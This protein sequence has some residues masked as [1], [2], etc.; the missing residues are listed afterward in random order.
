MAGRGSFIES[1]PLFG[2][3]LDDYDELFAEKLELL[4]KIRDER[5]RHLVRSPPPAA[6]R[7]RRLATSRP[8][9][10][11]GLGRGRRLAAV[12]RPRRHARPAAHDR[13]HRRAARAAS[14]R[15]SSCTARRSPAPATTPAQA[16]VAINTHAF[17]G[18]TSAQA[19]SAFAAPYL[20]GDEPHRARARL[21]AVGPARVRGA[22]LAPRGAR[23]RVAAGGRREDPLRPRA[24]RSSALH[25]P[26]ERRRRRARRR[27]ALDGALRHRGRAGGARRGGAAHGAGDRLTGASRALWMQNGRPGR[28]G[29]IHVGCDAPQGR[30]EHL[31]LE[32]E[33]HA[34][35]A[36][37]DARDHRHRLAD[38]QPRRARQ[39]FAKDAAQL[40]ARQ[41]RAEAVVHAAA[42]EADVVVRPA[43]HVEPVGILERAPVTVPRAVEHDHLLPRGDRLAADLRVAGRG[44]AERRHRARPAHELLDG[45]G[46]ARLEI[47]DQVGALARVVVER[48]RRVARRVAG[49][50][51]AGDRQQVEECGDLRSAEP[52]AVDLGVHERRHQ[53]V[54]RM[55]GALLGERG[56]HLRDRPDALPRQ[57]ERVAIP[58]DV[59][60]AEVH[61]H[62]GGLLQAL[63]VLT[64]DAD[65]LGDHPHRDLLGAELDEVALG[66]L[67]QLRDD[68]VR[69]ERDPLLE[70]RDLARREGRRDEP[71]QLRVARGV[72]RD[73]RRRRLEHLRRRVEEHDAQ[74]RA[75]GPLVARDAA[76]VVIARQ[77]PVAAAGHLG[78]QREALDRPPPGDRA[79]AAQ[80]RER[81]V[82]L[83]RRVLQ[84]ELQ[85]G[86]VEAESGGGRALDRA[87]RRRIR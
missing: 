12:G 69:V 85:R 56:R 61:Q 52:L 46:Q 74:P 27:A 60:V 9:S 10:A 5:A 68:L 39:Q 36:V 22:A 83:C 50:V 34:L 16:R 28:P 82:A 15:S 48:L 32:H 66:V 2:Y 14:C 26:D 35:D 7:R 6:R 4:L 87:H 43:A 18:E 78:R 57:L 11:A 81:L 75:E 40:S 37:D 73:E 20:A 41:R 45:V 25:R 51:V 29:R 80:R 31:R 23:R 77:R 13:D 21:A 55:L 24:L 59:G 42:A 65:H 38:P 72:H 67:K 44:A 1:F 71:A 33:R 62:L 8:G 58:E 54:G 19:D 84:P 86:Q 3:D 30:P 49:R 53:V 76:D 47:L 70:A 79:L 64:A 63:V 17:V